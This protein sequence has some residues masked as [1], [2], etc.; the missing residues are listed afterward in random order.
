[1]PAE[2]STHVCNRGCRRHGCDGR[3]TAPAATEPTIPAFYFDQDHDGQ[4]ACLLTHDL[5]SELK[6]LERG[7]FISHGKKFRFDAKA[8]LRELP[9]F[10]V[11][12]SAD[13]CESIS[14]AEMKANVG[15]TD[16]EPGEPAPRGVVR[17]ARQKVRA[18]RDREG[19]DKNA[20]LAFGSRPV[21]PL[22]VPGCAGS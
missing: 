19:F 21:Y 3:G 22:E 15:I 18:I 13:S 14:V 11:S 16:D 5:A 6:R 2:T 20:P 12:E 1:M 4:P 9:N 8:P 10:K 17:H 7:R